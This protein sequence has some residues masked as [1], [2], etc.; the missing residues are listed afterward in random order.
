MSNVTS[1]KPTAR[2]LL[3]GIKII[4]VDTHVS[5]WPELWTERAPGNLKA[6]MP[7][8]VGDGAD[9]RWVIDEDTF[10]APGC[11]ATAILKD[12]SKT[13]SYDAVVTT[14]IEAA[15]PACYEVDARLAMMD[16]QGI[17]AQVAY[18]NIMGFSGQNAM[19]V[20]R[21]LRLAAMQIYNDAMA[22]IQQ[23]SSDRILPMAM[24]PWWDLDETMKELERCVNRG[25]RGI[26]WN[27][28]TH[29][30]GLPS[31][32]D[33]YWNRLWEACVAN[34]LPVNFHIGASDESMSWSTQTPLPSFS[35]D[36]KLAMGAVM[37]F[38]GNLRVMGNV[39]A[40]R[41]LEKWPTLKIVSVESGAGWIPYLLEALEYM[42]V[43]A[44]LSYETAPREVFRRQI[45]ACTF[46]ERANF[47]ETVHQV[48]ADNIMFETD[49]PHPA[50]L[51]PDGLDYMTDAIAGLT[52][53]ERFKIFSGNAAKLYNIDIS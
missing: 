30:H 51:Y 18:P 5:E 35:N 39:L 50:C 48:G 9:R 29:S 25:V 7:R 3:A 36:Q 8:I 45:Y 37:L 14:T 11:A 23:R 6:R 33:P 47:V 27:P 42:S 46:F 22:D 49:F 15:D 13:H 52:P 40:S 4:D 20:D 10:L 1:L 53:E 41:F 21:E 38:I 24:L 31:I 34:K 26:N 17:H 2:D 19:K 44:G 32:A 12:G 43:E 16:A 28:D